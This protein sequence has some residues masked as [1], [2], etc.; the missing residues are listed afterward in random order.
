MS[1]EEL[2]E[3]LES[4]RAARLRKIEE[5]IAEFRA[6]LSPADAALFSPE[7]HLIR[8][9]PNRVIPDAI[10]ELKADI[11]LMGTVSRSGLSGLLLGNTAEEVLYGVDCSVAI[12][13]PDGFIC[14]VEAS[15]TR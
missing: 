7:I 12:V 1:S 13:K 6:E 8:G 10:N 11:L 4:E 5:L 14:P 2:S 9:A 3:L 15:P